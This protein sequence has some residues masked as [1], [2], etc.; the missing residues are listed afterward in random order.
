MLYIIGLGLGEQDISL[1]ALEIARKADRIYLENY[2]SPFLGSLKKLQ[3][4]IGKKILLADRDLVEINTDEILQKAKKQ[5]VVFFVVGDAF[6]AT[7]HVDLVLRAKEQKIKTE[8]LHNASI[9][10]AVAESGL[11]LYKFGKIASIPFLVKGWLVDTPYDILKENKNAH[12]LFLLDLRPEEKMFMTSKQAIEFLLEVEK[13][14]GGRLFS[15]ET[16]CVICCALGTKKQKILYGKAKD[17]VK[18]TLRAF[19]QVLIIP[20]KLHFVEKEFL[21]TFKI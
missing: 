5:R 17:L 18:K 6:S 4:I 9:L 12:T 3:K 1:R 8:I 14:R 20:G 10:T 16:V 19:P 7:T 2:T 21:E 15:E 11:S 13:R